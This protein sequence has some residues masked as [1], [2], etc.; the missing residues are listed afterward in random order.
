MCACW[1]L[2]PAEFRSCGNGN[3]QTPQ[4]GCSE[5]EI[6]TATTQD[7]SVTFDISVVHRNEQ[8]YCFA[9]RIQAL[10]FRKSSPEL[11]IQC[12]SESCESAPRFNH[13]RLSMAAFDFI[14]TLNVPNVSDSGLY[15]LTADIRD[16][17][18]NM[19][20]CIS[21]NFSLTVTGWTKFACC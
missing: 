13:S 21:K 17:S 2:G 10:T 8:N 7:S 20:V 5:A 6:L 4:K 14:L 3:T 12:N 1:S 19:R 9:Q 15:I 11:M 16:P 18:N